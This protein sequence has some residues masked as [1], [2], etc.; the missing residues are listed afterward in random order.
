LEVTIEFAP[1]PEGYRFGY[2]DTNRVDTDNL[3]QGFGFSLIVLA[4][5]YFGSEVVTTTSENFCYDI[6]LNDKEKLQCT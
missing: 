1:T 5:H 2:C 3:R 6:Q 4:A